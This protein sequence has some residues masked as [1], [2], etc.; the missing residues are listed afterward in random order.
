MRLGTTATLLAAGA[1]ALATTTPAHAY[2]FKPSWGYAFIDDRPFN[3]PNGG[4]LLPATQV[5]PRGR[6]NDVRPPDGYD[7]RVT[8]Y[9]FREGSAEHSM[10]TESIDEGDFVSTPFVWR[11]D[12]SPHVVD[13]IAFD[14]CKVRPGGSAVQCEPRLRISRPDPAGP[15]GSPPPPPP[16]TDADRDGTSPPADCNDNNATVWPGAPEVAGNGIDENCDGTDPP[17]RITAVVQ[18]AWKAT[19]R[20]ARVLRLR[21][22]D[23]PAN[24]RAQVRCLGRRCA[25]ERRGLPV[26]RDGRANLRP[27]VRRRLRPKTTLEVRITAPNSIGKVVRYPIRR[28]RIPQGRTMCLPPGTR[29]PTRC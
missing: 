28:R 10:A 8:V 3:D 2:E 16:P 12:I 19:S 5:S 27:L 21:V 14:F 26:G 17:A 7:V 9:T 11:F 18:S 1:L 23:A 15:P 20:G 4:A 13:Y 6:L 29:K 22:R 24:A 25:F